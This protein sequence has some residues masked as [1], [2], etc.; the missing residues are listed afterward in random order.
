MGPVLAPILALSKVTR[1][2]EVNFRRQMAIKTPLE[3]SALPLFESGRKSVLKDTK[4]DPQGNLLCNTGPIR[5]IFAFW[6]SPEVLSRRAR[7][8]FGARTKINEKKRGEDCK[9]FRSTR[10]ETG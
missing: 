1:P 3:S 2:G 9:N 5:F 10:Q 8:E 4:I 7:S 6:Q